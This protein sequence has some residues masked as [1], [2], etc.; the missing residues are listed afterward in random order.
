M[1]H[2]YKNVLKGLLEKNEEWLMENILNYA[3]KQGYSVYASTLKEA[4]RLSISG[5]SASILEA[6]NYFMDIP[7]LTP[8]EAFS[9]DPV[10]LF[11]IIEA[12]RHRERGISLNMFLGLM[13]YYRQSYIDMIRHEV[14]DPSVRQYCELFINRVFDRIEIGFCVE[15]SGSGSDKTIH[16]MQI[17]NRKMTNEKNK[18]LTIFESIPNPVIILNSEKKIDSMNLSAARLFNEKLVSGSQYYCLSRDRQLEVDQSLEQNTGKTI[19]PSFFGRF[20]LSELLPWLKDEFEKFHQNNLISMMFEKEINNNDNNF[21]F[22]IRFSK[23]LDV[24]KKFDGTIIIMEDITSLKNAQAEIKTLS[25]LVPICS[26]C[27]NIRDDKGFWQKIEQ[28]VSERSE[29]AFSHGICPECA[30]KYYPDFDIYE[31]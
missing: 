24:S 7:E 2:H 31:D 18:F 20:H 4:W 8:E 14:L 22:R 29:A 6:L 15:W 5:L 26:H 27:K 16:E 11:G 25:G 17:N 30:K 1:G 9:K 13:K 21:I 12:Q 10:A 23:S 3:I 28:Y 19:G